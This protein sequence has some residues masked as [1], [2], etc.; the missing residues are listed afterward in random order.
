[1]DPYTEVRDGGGRQAVVRN[2]YP[3]ERQGVTG[4]GPVAVRVPKVRERSGGGVVF[5]S[6]W[7]PP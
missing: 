6:A 5:R 2:G 7:V 4:M 3:P 1:M